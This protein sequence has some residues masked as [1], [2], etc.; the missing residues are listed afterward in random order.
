MRAR[1]LVAFLVVPV[2]A[3]AACGGGEGGSGVTASTLPGA[4]SRVTGRVLAGPVCPVVQDPPDPACADRPVQSAVIVIT[5][6]DGAE[7]AAVS[8]DE[9]GR[10]AIA[11]PPG[12]YRLTPR[13]VEGLL[14]TAAP[15]DLVVSPGET[16]DLFFLYDTGIR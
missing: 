10:F 2:F 5:R 7:M 3:L 14:G 11:L 12:S 8:S 1:L 16:V 9:A 15:T 4:T 13:P 6:A